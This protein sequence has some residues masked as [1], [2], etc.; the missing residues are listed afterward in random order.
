MERNDVWGNQKYWRKYGATN[1]HANRDLIIYPDGE[2]Y[3]SKCVF[4]HLIFNDSCHQQIIQKQ[5]IRT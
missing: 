4:L 1:S 3:F 2:F 5:T